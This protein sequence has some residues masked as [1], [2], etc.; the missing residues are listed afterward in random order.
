[1]PGA[2]AEPE[3]INGENH[4]QATGSLDTVTIHTLTDADVLCEVPGRLSYFSLLHSFAGVELAPSE[5]CD[6]ATS[7]P[8]LAIPTEKSD[9]VSPS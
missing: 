3:Q 8:E 4:Q 6:V 1:L 9:K 7:F 5:H 2:Y